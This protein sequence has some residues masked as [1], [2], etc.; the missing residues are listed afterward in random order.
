MS[1]D[2]GFKVKVEGVDCWVEPMD[3]DANVTWNVRE[4]IEKST[5]LPWLNND[6]NGL[7]IDV[8]PYIEHGVKELTEHP[9]KYKKYEA[10]NGW[11]TVESTLRFFQRILIEWGYFK[12]SY[13]E[14][15]SVVTFWIY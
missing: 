12:A 14:L 9:G 10:Q 15:V 1:Y 3:C 4:M 5:G 2:I 6:N 13:P 7:C 8:I 11:G